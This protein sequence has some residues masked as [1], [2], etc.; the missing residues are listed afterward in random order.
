M[1]ALQTVAA[2]DSAGAGASDGMGVPSYGAD[3]LPLRSASIL[4]LPALLVAGCHRGPRDPV[5]EAQDHL[6]TVPCALDGSPLFRSDCT[7][8]RQT[9]PGGLVLVIHHPDGGFRKLLVAT[10]GRGVVT[11]D[12]AGEAA[13]SV[14]DPAEIE[15]AV[16]GD[17]YHLPATVKG[18][19]LPPR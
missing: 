3:M 16:D 18:Q 2:R 14:V 12:G 17:R 7:V 10:D 8:E 9:A 11:A 6:P 13:V 5:V 4:L 1:P 19:S 15:V